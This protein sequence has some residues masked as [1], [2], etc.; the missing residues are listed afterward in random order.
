M[1]KVCC[2]ERSY[3]TLWDD[4]WYWILFMLPSTE[5]QH[6]WRMSQEAASSTGSLT[7][8]PQP[9]EAAQTGW[10]ICVYSWGG[11][12]LIQIHC[13]SLYSPNCEWVSYRRDFSSEVVDVRLITRTN[14]GGRGF[15][16]CVF[17]RGLAARQLRVN[18]A[19]QN[20]DA[21]V[22]AVWRKKRKRDKDDWESSYFRHLWIIL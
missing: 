4:D 8:Y 21:A 12:G 5:F 17:A 14:V 7:S 18:T 10:T 3:L 6:I 1:W 19:K 13:E 11:G 9:S 2:L 20:P 22:G 16:Q 15:Q